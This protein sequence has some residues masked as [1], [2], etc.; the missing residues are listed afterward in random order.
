MNSFYLLYIDLFKSK[1][2]KI[3]ESYGEQFLCVGRAFPWSGVLVHQLK[4][5]SSL[6]NKYYSKFLV[7]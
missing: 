6:D 2:V 1:I 4:K 5:I 3:T 7:L